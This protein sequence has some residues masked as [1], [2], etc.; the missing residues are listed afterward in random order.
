M[1]RVRLKL[2]DIPIR[3]IK[4]WERILLLFAPTYLTADVTLQ[5]TTYCMSKKLFGKLYYIKSWTETNTNKV[6]GLRMD[7]IF[8]DEAESMA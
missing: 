2:F 8:I 3:T 6:N 1:S 5:E 4:W 7:Y